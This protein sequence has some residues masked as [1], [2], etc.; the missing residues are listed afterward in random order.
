MFFIFLYIL[1]IFF[2]FVYKLEDLKNMNARELR[3]FAK[4]HNIHGYAK[5]SKRA[6]LLNFLS[7]QRPE[8]EL[9]RMTLLELKALAKQM[10]I[11]GRSKFRNKKDLIEAIESFR[12]KTKKE[13]KKDWQ[14]PNA[15]KQFPDLV[16]NV[17]QSKLKNEAG[18]KPYQTKKKQ[19]R[20]EKRD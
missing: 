20:R 12:G 1:I 18:A 19:T 13:K 10:G 6:D 15:A 8:N 7:N 2:I 9:N 16:E 11:P 5:Y 4:T 3:N 17:N 14:R